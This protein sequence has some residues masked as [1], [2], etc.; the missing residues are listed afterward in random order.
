MSYAAFDLETT[1][2]K[3]FKRK[4]SPFGGVNRIV[5]FG[6]KYKGDTHNTGMYFYE[7]QGGQRVPTWFI[8]MLDR[9]T[10]LLGFNIKFDIL[11]AINES[12][13][14][15]DAWVEFINK[16]GM[17]WDGQLGEYL[18]H[19][20]QQ[21]HHML[22]MDEV[23]PRYGGTLKNDAVKALW[24]AGIDTTE[25]DRDL[26]M[27]YLIGVNSDDGDIGNTER[28]AL[29]QIKAFRARGGMQS[30]LLNM[31]ALCFT[32]EA[33]HNGM[34]VDK[35]L[36]LELAA[37]VKI[38]LDEATAR[39]ESYIPADLPFQFKWTSRFHKSALIFGGSI[40]YVAKS[41]IVDDDGKQTYVQKEELH[42]VLADG[43]TMSKERWH[44]IMHSGGFYESDTPH[45]LG[46]Y[47][48]DT[49]KWTV[50]LT[51][52]VYYSSG[53]NKGEA[54]TKKVKVDDHTKPKF[55]NEDFLYVF[56]GYTQP[57]KKWEGSTP[58][59][60]ST[61]ADIIVE[62]G[63]RDIP[64][65]KDLAARAGLAKDLG[66]YYI[67]TDEET[68]EQKGMLTLVGAD[69]VVH[70][71]LNMVNTVTGRLSSSD[72]NL[73][74][75]SGG[76]K[77]QVKRVFVSR[78]GEYV[79]VDG[80]RVY[81]PAGKI[82]QSDFTALE[83]YVQA[84]LTL[85]AQLIADLKLGLDMHCVRLSQKLGLTYEE[86]Y[87]RYK[88]GDKDIA[89]GRK[90]AKEFSFQRAYG[91]G[92]AAIAA[93]TGM[94]VEDVEALVKAEA[95]RYPEVDDFYVMLTAEIAQ[96]RVPTQRFCQHPSVPGMQCQLGRSHYVTPDG[97]M[98][99]YSESPSPEWIAKKPASKGGT[100]QS[101]SPTEIKNYVVQGTGGEWAKAAMWLAV[102][103]FYKR[104]NFGGRALLVNQV[105][106]A[107][108][109]D[110][111]NE[112]AVTAGALL[113]ACML[114]ASCFMEYH[115]KWT[116]P[117]PV[118]CETK[119]GLSMMEES[120]MPD[121][122]GDLVHQYRAWVRGTFIANYQ[123]S[124]EKE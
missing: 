41:P 54:K 86:V 77:S 81:I 100:A 99:S 19:G 31:G 23:A 108:Y 8:D 45:E 16:G 121:E 46:H 21:E 85:C 62:L 122:F 55:R 50:P 9:S 43:T 37:Q 105:H 14:N 88:E 117:V 92:V 27:E 48:E 76:A 12:P 94:S 106:D 1:I 90:G 97:K 40:K 57:E 56:P 24:E 67:T 15:Y 98:Y 120:D 111:D 112:H 83:V 64:F 73:Q 124:F 2:S 93:S 17:V 78:F 70:H 53:K 72:P 28:I 82:V 107:I 66:T 75:V 59:V 39:M 3:V 44:E 104:K 52:P 119:Y 58:G 51:T 63:S 34:F 13:A 11:H 10:L 113:H 36:G 87:R 49:K 68:G 5:A 116:I 65:L 71:S 38:E 35:Q 110:A 96:N 18:L 103:A 123:P 6:V 33:E 95:E 22:S 101:F 102:R 114:E 79:Y 118:P 91:A 20:M 30:A 109:V 25:I 115:F 26:L 80:N 32:I 29:G 61:A 42:Y 47:D 4:A 7:G 84:V 60:Y 74:N 69:G 89:K